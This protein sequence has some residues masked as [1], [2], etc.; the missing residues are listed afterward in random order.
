MTWER[1]GEGELYR[2][3]DMETYNIMCK[4]DRQ[5]EFAA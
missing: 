1:G 5:R 3:S 2:E 4:I